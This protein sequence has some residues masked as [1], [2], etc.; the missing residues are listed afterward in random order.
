MSKTCRKCRKKFPT[1]SRSGGKQKVFSSRKYCFNCS[2]P[3]KHNT[4]KLHLIQKPRKRR[5]NYQSVKLFRHRHKQKAVDYLGSKCKLCGYNK[6]LR[7][8]VFHHRDPL[9][10]EFDWSHYQNKSWCSTKLELDKCDLLCSNCHA[11]VH[12]EHSGGRLV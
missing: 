4:L 8:L 7:A 10:K 9:E 1:S 12:E 2:P 5:G 11:E 3:G 6:C